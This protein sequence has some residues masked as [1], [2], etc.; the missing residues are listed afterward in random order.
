MFIPKKWINFLY[1]LGRGTLLSEAIED[2]VFSWNEWVISN[3]AGM[4]TATFPKPIDPNKFKS[5][6][7]AAGTPGTAVVNFG[8][9]SHTA[10]SLTFRGFN[11]ET[12]NHAGT[13]DVFIQ[14][15]LKD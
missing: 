4:F 3:G 15:T 2:T 9:V 11:T 8:Y 7:F 6:Q 13:V 1:K 5:V 10:T 14:V 12:R